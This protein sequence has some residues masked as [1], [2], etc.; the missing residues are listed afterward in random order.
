MPRKYH[1]YLVVI[2]IALALCVVAVIAGIHQSNQEAKESHER[3]VRATLIREGDE[4]LAAA[5][6]HEA[7]VKAAQETKTA[8]EISAYESKCS[9]TG[10]VSTIEH[11]VKGYTW[12]GTCHVDAVP[13]TETQ[14]QSYPTLSSI[15]Q[16]ECES[17]KGVG[18]Q[19]GTSNNGPTC[20]GPEEAKCLNEGKTVNGTE[21]EAG[22]V[23][24]P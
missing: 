14:S 4:R 13:Q 15:R 2:V 3:Q 19:I 22:Y 5:Q 11:N 1:K 21:G 10:G 7:E 24:E 9:S 16:H 18:S 20:N 17:E 23:C 6:Q 8:N 12:Y